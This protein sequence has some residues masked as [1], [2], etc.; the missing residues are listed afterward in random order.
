MPSATHDI[1]AQFTGFGAK[2]EAD[3]K[4][5][6]LTKIQYTPKEWNE[7]DVDIKITHCKLF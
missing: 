5:Y 1:P 4:G 2:N 7:L 6:T 3:G